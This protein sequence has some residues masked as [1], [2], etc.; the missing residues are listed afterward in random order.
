MTHLGAVKLVLA[1]TTRA[2]R[3]HLDAGMCGPQQ[4]AAA[5]DE[6]GD[7]NYIRRHAG[8]MRDAGLSNATARLFSNPAG[9]YGSMVNERVGAGNWESGEELGDTWA[10]RNAYSYGRCPA[11]IPTLLDAQHA[12]RCDRLRPYPCSNC[13]G[14]RSGY[15]E[16]RAW[17]MLH[18]HATSQIDGVFAP[19]QS[20]SFVH[21]CGTTTQCLSMRSA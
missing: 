15:K 12:R 21:R 17:E 20:R 1:S 3:W 4:R 13:L 18:A 16:F 2:S 8:S 6:P 9:D 10:S 19:L 14:L 7:M 5:A 11:R